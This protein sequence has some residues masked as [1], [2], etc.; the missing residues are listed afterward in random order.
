MGACP[1][2]WPPDAPPE[3]P[4]TVTIRLEPELARLIAL[5]EE[6]DPCGSAPV[7]VASPPPSCPAPPLLLCKGWSC[8][9]ASFRCHFR[10][11]LQGRGV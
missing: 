9:L 10:T 4:S 8:P 5:A 6:P 7:T 2:P 1:Q 3:G 11:H